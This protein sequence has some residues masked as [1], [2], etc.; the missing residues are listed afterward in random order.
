MDELAVKSRDITPV[1][2]D[3]IMRLE[4][5]LF[6]APEHVDLDEQTEHYFAPG[7]YVRKLTIPAGVVLT[8]KIHRYEIM[9]ILVSGTIKVTTDDGVE[10]LTG[11]LIFNS[12]AGTKKAGYAITDTIWL[13]VHPT[14]LTD[15]DEIERE[16][17]APSFEALEQEQ[18]PQLPRSAEDEK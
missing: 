18:K 10:E 8:G 1:S 2:R 4:D 16:F 3:Q 15:L 6:A 7:I 11:P 9:N 13:N 5:A 12:Q 17:I 14:E